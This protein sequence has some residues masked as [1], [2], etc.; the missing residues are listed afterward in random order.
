MPEVSSKRSVQVVPMGSMGSMGSMSYKKKKIPAALRSQ[1]WISKVG[2][3]F[4]VKCLTT[5]CKNTMNPF[6]FEVGHDLAESKGGA[7][8]LE[9]L[10]PIC[11]NCNRSMGNTHTFKEWCSMYT[12]LP[13]VLT[14]TYG[15]R[16]LEVIETKTKWY[17]FCMF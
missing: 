1:V 7:T 13:E 14:K 11:S 8:V 2:E 9:N 16:S 4:N 3:Q 15:K 6:T 5:W 10:V 17:R 12:N